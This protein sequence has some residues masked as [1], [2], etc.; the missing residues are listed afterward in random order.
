M[1]DPKVLVLRDHMLSYPI[2]PED[3]LV[4]TFFTQY[5]CFHSLIGRIIRD[6]IFFAA[7]AKSLSGYLPRLHFLLYPVL[8]TICTV[9][10]S[11]PCPL[12]SLLLLGLPHPSILLT[13]I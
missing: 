9:I 12:A 4:G 2:E 11:S 3:L 6:C 1:H 7:F 10:L 8:R 5:Y 13:D